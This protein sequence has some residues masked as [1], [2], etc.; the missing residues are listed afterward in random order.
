MKRF[1]INVFIFGC[2]C[3]LLFLIGEGVVRHLPNS[4]TS[5]KDYIENSGQKIKT[6]IL[7]SS[8]TYYGLIPELLGDSVFNL[9]NISQTPEYDLALLKHFLVKMPNLKRIIIP[10][11]YF[12]YVDPEIEDD[13][14][15]T[16][17]IK[18]KTKMKLPVHPDFSIYNLEITDFN[19]YKGQ[20]ANLILKRPSNKCSET[21]FGLGY[22]LENRE[23]DWQ[24]LGEKRASAHTVNNPERWK[25]VRHTQQQLLDLAISNGCEVIFIT[26]PGYK[27]YTECFDS[28][29]ENIMRQNIAFL[30]E[31]YQVRYLDFLRDPNFTENDFYDP[32]H[33][34]E[35]GAKKLTLLL[36]E[37]I[38]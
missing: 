7:G 34:S 3:C 4:Y 11:S 35:D 8:H 22:T 24:S 30:K 16:L 2:C 31:N 23:A 26:T 9:A 17:A 33:L 12:T 20:L 14:C 38:K 21:G 29:Q 18:Y 36:K 32:D 19:S 28:I 10:I 15:W 5:K 27:T 13:N 6:L 1:L 37:I 25:S